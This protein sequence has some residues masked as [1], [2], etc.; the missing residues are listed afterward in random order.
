MAESPR[1]AAF[2]ELLGTEIRMFFRDRKT[3]LISIVLPAVLT[4]VLMFGSSKVMEMRVEKIE[5]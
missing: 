1:R 2:L 3:L 5:E 4:P